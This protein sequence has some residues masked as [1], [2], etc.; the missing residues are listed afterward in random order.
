MSVA[1]GIAWAGTTFAAGRPV[2]DSFGVVEVDDIEGVRVFVNNEEIGKTGPDGRLF[3]PTLTSFLQNQISIDV[4]NVPLDFSFPESV[5]L[6]S[7]AYRSGAI[8]DFHAKRLQAVVGTVK[9]R[10]NGDV[11]PAEFY[12]VTLAVDGRPV[13]FVTGRG[14]EFYVEDV[15]PG[16]YAARLGRE[17][18]RV[19]V[20][21]RRAGGQGS[22]HRA[23]GDRLRRRQQMTG[24]SSS[25]GHVPSR[26]AIISR[27]RVSRC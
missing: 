2:T 25:N 3:V 22:A 17:W 12:A 16:R 1:G 6:V 7:P 27:G 15:K 10:L 13:T 14:G 19:H 20:R 5:K 18:P 8:V 9:I 4:A 24:T 21:V 23:S 11:K 26:V